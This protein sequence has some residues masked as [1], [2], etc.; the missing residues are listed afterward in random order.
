MKTDPYQWFA[1]R[2]APRRLTDSGFQPLSIDTFV[3]ATGQSGTTFSVGVLSDSS[4]LDFSRLVEAAASTRATPAPGPVFDVQAGGPHVLAHLLDT[5]LDML[6][7]TQGVADASGLTSDLVAV[8]PTQLL[9]A[10]ADD[11]PGI[12]VGPQDEAPGMLKDMLSTLLSADEPT[13][14]PNPGRI[15]DL[16]FLQNLPAFAWVPQPGSDPSDTVSPS[17]DSAVVVA[18]HA[19]IGS[20]DA[21]PVTRPDLIHDL[22]PAGATVSL[23]VL[24][25]HDDAAAVIGSDLFI[26]DPAPVLDL[27]SVPF[28]AVLPDPIVDPGPLV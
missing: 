2:T 9:F 21:I 14:N 24:F 12:P 18:D 23:A 4:G 5:P 13:P 26:T 6:S 1:E 7:P 22:T 16:G 11:S 19:A 28:A 8:L 27:G 15:A 25:A 17:R 3:G 10:A 20:G